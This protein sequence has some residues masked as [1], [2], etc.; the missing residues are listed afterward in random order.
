[1]AG[2]PTPHYNW[3]LPALTDPPDGPGQMAALG[4]A[5]DATVFAQAAKVTNVST[6]FI[7][8]P[9]WTLTTVFGLLIEIGVARLV[10]LKCDVTRT[11]SAITVPASGNLGDEAVVQLPASLRPQYYLA[12]SWTTGAISGG[13]YGDTTG[14]I[15]I[16]DAYPSQTLA[17]GHKLQILTF[18]TLN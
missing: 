7:A 2:T 15:K 14:L 9:N 11:T 17:I 12:G 1:M 16:S 3:P 5:A 6:G 18:Y 8:Q 13:W 10:Q 4:N